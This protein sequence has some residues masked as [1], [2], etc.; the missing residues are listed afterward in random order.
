MVLFALV[1]KGRDINIIDIGIQTLLAQS[2]T[3][4]VQIAPKC[5]QASI[6]P[7][8]MESE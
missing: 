2:S 4:A 7:K 8:S 6:L 1:E 5:R 3:L